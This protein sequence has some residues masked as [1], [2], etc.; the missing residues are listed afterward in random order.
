MH[1]VSQ[2]RQAILI[3]NGLKRTFPLTKN[4]NA[5]NNNESR[6][7]QTIPPIRQGAHTIISKTVSDRNEGSSPLGRQS[8]DNQ[9]K[10]NLRASSRGTGQAVFNEE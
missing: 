8:V 10:S 7:S 3:D 1:D 4:L 5:T 9:R 6:I 2:A